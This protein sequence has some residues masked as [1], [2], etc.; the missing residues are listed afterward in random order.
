MWTPELVRHQREQRR[1]S[2]RYAHPQR[3][4][5][6]LIVLWE[7][8]RARE[9]PRGIN[10]GIDPMVYSPRAGTPMDFSGAQ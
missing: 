3:L 5:E 7:R 9:I 4:F 6:I 2:P 1:V 8:R 10:L